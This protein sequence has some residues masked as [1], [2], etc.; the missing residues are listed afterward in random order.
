MESGRGDYVDQYPTPDELYRTV[1][2]VQ[3]DIHERVFAQPF[4]KTK[5]DPGT[6]K[7]MPSMQHLEL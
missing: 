4:H 6:I 3:S 1:N 2:G 5:Y 7:R